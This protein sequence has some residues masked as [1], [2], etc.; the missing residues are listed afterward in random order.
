MVS[1]PID[2]Q[3]FAETAGAWLLAKG[4]ESDV[5]ISCRTRLARNVDQYPFVTRLEPLGN[6][7]AV[8]FLAAAKPIFR[9]NDGRDT[10]R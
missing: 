5:V 4:P 7:L 1:S 9:V 8:G 10:D 6:S 2:P 3:R